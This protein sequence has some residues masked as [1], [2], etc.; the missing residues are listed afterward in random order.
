MVQII[1]L[2]PGSS[3][4]GNGAEEAGGMKNGPSAPTTIGMTVIHRILSSFYFQ[5]VYFVAC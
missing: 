5:Q 1:P 4:I 3:S 2:I